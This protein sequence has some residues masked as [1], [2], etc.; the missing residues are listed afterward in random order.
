MRRFLAI[1]F[2]EAR[3]GL[4]ACEEPECFPYPVETVASRPRDA[5][6]DRIASLSRTKLTTDVVLGLP[7]REDGTEGTAAEKI[8][9]FANRLRPL[10]A[11]SITLHFQDEYGSTKQAKEHMR[12]SGKKEKHQRSKI[13]QAAAVVILEDFLRAKG[14]I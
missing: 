13:D 12:N 9:A 6:L 1:D 5:A 2:G 10:L 8:R 14:L 3:I 11:E 4:A 7:I